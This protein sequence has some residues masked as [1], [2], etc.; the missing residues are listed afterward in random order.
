MTDTYDKIPAQLPRWLF[1]P[2]Y[3]LGELTLNVAKGGT[4]KTTELAEVT[5]RVTTGRAWPDGTPNGPPSSVIWITLEDSPNMLA[6][7]FIAAGADRSKIIDLSTVGG[8]PFYL[9]GTDGDCLQAL[10]DKIIETGDVRLVVI[11][12]LRK[13]SK[14]RLTDDTGAAAILMPLIFLARRT[15]V[16]IVANHHT[17]KAGSVAGS[18]AVVDTARHTLMLQD[19]DDT[20]LIQIAIHKTNIT[21][22]DHDPIYYEV[23]GEGEKAHVVWLDEDAETHTAER[24]EELVAEAVTSA[25]GPVTEQQITAA[26]GVPY[27]DVRVIMDTLADREEVISVAP[28]VWWWRV[29]ETSGQPGNNLSDTERYR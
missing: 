24:A 28:G 14:R 16:A 23:E 4:G 19:E 1:F 8:K 6:W 27:S 26:T 3:P 13:V 5:A 29:P 7:K 15:G 11:D 18:G 22:K 12:T 9:D 2:W 10:E 20:G 21:R 17:T 25:P